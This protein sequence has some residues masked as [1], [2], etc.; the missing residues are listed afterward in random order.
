MSV[1]MCYP[2]LIHRHRVGLADIMKKHGQPQ[3]LVIPH[4][5]QRA[6]RV[7]SHAVCVVRMMLLRL[8]G[9]VKFRQKHPCNPQIIR[10]PQILRVGR[11][12][13]LHQLRL[14]TFRTDL[15]QGRGKSPNL[16]PGPAVDLISQLCGKT[17]C[18][19]NPQRILTEA[20]CGLSHTPDDPGLH[21]IHSPEKV[22]QALF[23]I[24]RHGIDGKIPA[25]QILLQI[26]GKGNLPGMT[27]VLICSVNQTLMARLRRQ[28]KR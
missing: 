12:H 24:I 26:R 22:Y 17:D 3:H 21:V 23:L 10:L 19:Q 14:N 20:L 2:F 11:H 9:P 25:L 16:L 4:L 28:N 27:A 6:K 1:K 7:L 15:F 8:H 18:A 13:H 5:L